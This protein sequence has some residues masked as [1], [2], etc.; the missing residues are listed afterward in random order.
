MACD[1]SSEALVKQ[2]RVNED[3]QFDYALIAGVLVGTYS[4]IYIAS[5]TLLMMNISA[6]DITIEIDE[7]KP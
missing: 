6:K 1:W 4:S 5:S 3:I 7:E 2:E